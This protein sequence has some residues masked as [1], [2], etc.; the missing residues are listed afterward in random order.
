ESSLTSRERAGATMLLAIAG[1][2]VLIAG[3]LARRNFRLGR[4]DRRGAFRFALALASLRFLSSM[5]GANHVFSAGEFLIII[6]ICS[7]SL[8]TAAVGWLL[9]IGIEPYVRRRWRQTL[10]SWDRLLLGQLRDP[11]LRRDLLPGVPA[12]PLVVPR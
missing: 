8:L 1:A 12:V 5:F 9:Y 2:M 3:I 6:M 4:G 7:I 10:L 11:L